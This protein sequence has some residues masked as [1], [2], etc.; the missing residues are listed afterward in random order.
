L[1]VARKVALIGR[2]SDVVRVFL[3]GRKRVTVKS[4]IVGKLVVRAS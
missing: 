1:G 3:R 4:T 2:R